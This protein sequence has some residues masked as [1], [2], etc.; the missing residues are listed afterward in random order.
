M[1]RRILLTITAV[2]TVFSIVGGYVFFTSQQ[3]TTSENKSAVSKKKPPTTKNEKPKQPPNKLTLGKNKENSHLEKNFGGK[4]L[5]VE[6]I[7]DRAFQSSLK[8]RTEIKLKPEKAPPKKQDIKPVK[9][10]PSKPEKEEDSS[11]PF[12]EKARIMTPINNQ[13]DKLDLAV[14]EAKEPL[15]IGAD[16]TKL[17]QLI[18]TKQLSYKELAGIYLNRIKKYDQNGL[19]LNAITE[20]NP[21][22]I[23]EAEQLDKDNSANKSALYGMPVLLKDN[24]GTKELPTS[25][26]TVALKDWVIGEDATIVENLKANG[27]LILGKTNMSEWAAGMDE[28][29]PNG[30]S[31]KKGQSK[32]PYSSDLDPSGSSSGSATGATSDFAA[33]AIGTE[34]N[35]S[36]IIPASAQSAV[37]YKPSQGLINNKGIIPLSSRF[38][39]PGPLTRTVND[40]YLTTNALINT[41]SNP[42]L[43]TDSLQGKRIGLLADGESNE[44]TAV[45]KKI[46]YDLK[47]AGAIIIEGVAVGEF[48][49]LDTDYALLLNADFKHDLNQFLNVNNAPMTTLESIIQFN[50]TNPARNMKYGQSELVKSQQSTTTKLQ[51]DSL[52]SNLIQ[53]AQ[54]ELDSMLQK[55]KLDAVVTIGMGGSVTF[56]APIAGNPE[57]TIPA[58]YD[59]K[60]NQPISLTFITARNSDTT[61]LNMGYSYEQQSKN[62]KSPNLK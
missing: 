1:K 44:E 41:T 48:E 42:P 8:K 50:Q 9:P 28:E 62:R 15:I 21:T 57:L 40:A 18:A 36:I 59:E 14:L 25:A 39:T 54:N 22:I 38:D 20:I 7:D 3:T 55:D 56:L 37:G 16:V 30:Y 13:L 34:T 2:C 29:L 6:G 53:E 61:L 32:N 45:I 31:G 27:A 33:I 46:K 24:I 17:Q 10:I 26:G 60:T 12:Y 47:K 51:A 23:A 5:Q 11:S 49:Q 19:T 43:S 52:A 4:Q 58:G 35:G